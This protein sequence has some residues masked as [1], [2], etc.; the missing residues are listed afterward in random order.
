M[1]NGR[2]HVPQLETKSYLNETKFS[3]KL[4]WTEPEC[5]ISTR[6]FGLGTMEN[7]REHVHKLETLI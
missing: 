7:Y 6:C 2:N 4:T 1:E 3:L 5:T